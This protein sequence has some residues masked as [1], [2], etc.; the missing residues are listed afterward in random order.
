MGDQATGWAFQR[1]NAAVW[2]NRI[3]IPVVVALMVLIASL[4]RNLALSPGLLVVIVIWVPLLGWSWWRAEQRVGR[5]VPRIRR[6]LTEHPWRPVPVRLVRPDQGQ[7]PVIEISDG[8]A[9]RLRLLGAPLGTQHVIARERRMWLVG[10]EAGVA[11]LRADGL[12]G[13]ILGHVLTAALA[14]P[15]GAT[16]TPWRETEGTY[17]PYTGSDPVSRPGSAEAV[18]SVLP[19]VPYTGSAADDVVAS[20][21]ASR[22]MRLVR[23]GQIVRAVVRICLVLAVFVVVGISV[24]GVGIAYAA[25]PGV[26]LALF[27]VALTLIERRRARNVVQLPALLRSGP[28]Q[29]VEARFEAWSPGRN[30]AGTAPARGELGGVAVTI[31][32]ASMDLM[33]Y[34]RET[35]T[36]WI[37]GRPEPGRA[38]AVGIAGYPVLARATFPA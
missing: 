24:G 32:R 37:A 14:E 5:H 31:P 26:L 12:T 16:R 8:S 30:L 2:R 22:A 28:W 21:L 23:R 13:L 10:P 34:A 1:L 38:A 9:T 27:C 4:S 18:A 19:P 3:L 6:M 15:A 25:V 33:A 36:L 35:G 11:V 29:R 20:W 7:A 17:G